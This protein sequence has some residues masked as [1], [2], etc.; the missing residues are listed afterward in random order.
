MQQLEDTGLEHWVETDPESHNSP[1]SN[2]LRIRDFGA[3]G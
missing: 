3:H 1:V 2:Y